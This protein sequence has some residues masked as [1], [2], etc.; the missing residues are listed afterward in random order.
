MSN[1]ISERLRNSDYSKI[2]KLVNS[3]DPKYCLGLISACRGLDTQGN[4]S[5]EITQHNIDEN[6]HKN[7]V[8]SGILMH[9][10]KANKFGVMEIRGTY[11]EEGIGLVEEISYLVYTPESRKE[12]LKAIL[13][14]LGKVFKQDTIMII[15]NHIVKLEWLQPKAKPLWIDEF[16]RSK[17]HITFD[18]NN[19]SDI[20]SRVGTRKYGRKFKAVS[21]EECYINYNTITLWGYNH[22]PSILK[23]SR[24]DNLKY[25]REFEET[26]KRY[27]L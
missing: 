17:P 8:N 7:N 10:L 24:V 13:V 14:E 2:I 18:Q 6:N 3:E 27:I 1:T 5:P 16:N 20:F 11:R 23:G 15:D 25:L 22:D 19:L 4:P 21:L 9:N 26:I 12:E